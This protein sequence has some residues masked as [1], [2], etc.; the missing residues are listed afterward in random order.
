MPGFFADAGQDDGYPG[1]ADADEAV[2]LR[3]PFRASRL[4]GAVGR[5]KNLVPPLQLST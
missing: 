3:F 1:S 4:A 2:C 5:C